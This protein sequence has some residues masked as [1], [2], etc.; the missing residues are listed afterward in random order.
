M[1]VIVDV[2]QKCLR[3]DCLLLWSADDTFDTSE[4]C[5]R[6]FHIMEVLGST[7]G[8]EVS[9]WP[10]ISISWKERLPD[11]EG[12][13]MLLEPSQADERSL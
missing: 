12:S 4:G 5:M 1:Q 3:S 13:S 11:D 9:C 10:G 2:L 8:M 6:T 7:D